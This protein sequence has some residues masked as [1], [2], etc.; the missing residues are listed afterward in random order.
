M[1]KEII[2]D[3]DCMTDTLNSYLKLKNDEDII[4]VMRDFIN[5]LEEKNI[6]RV[7]LFNNLQELTYE[8][9]EED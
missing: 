7:K 4:M 5:T 2:E 3:I 6:D 9:V 1:T 8:I